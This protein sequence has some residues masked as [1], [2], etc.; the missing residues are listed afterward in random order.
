[1]SRKWHVAIVRVVVLTAGLCVLPATPAHAQQAAD[2]VERS[3]YFVE[4]AAKA[5]EWL[6]ADKPREA[7]VIFEN[8]AA[9]YADLDD[10]GYVLRAIGD[11]HVALGDFA[12]A[13]AAFEKAVS[14]RPELAEKLASRLVETQLEGEPG[15]ALI[16]ELRVAA[17]TDRRDRAL[18]QWQLA[19][20]LE[21]K[22]RALLLESAAAFR[23]L[24]EA[25]FPV[26]SPR[27]FHFAERAAALEEIAEE[28]NTLIHD[29]QKAWSALQ[30]GRL[31][32]IESA[33]KTPNA[34]AVLSKLR[35]SWVV[36]KKDG[37][38]L[39][40]ELRGDETDCK[41]TLIVEGRPVALTD[42]QTQLIRRHHERI[43]AILM[44]AVEKTSAA[45]A[46]P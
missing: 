33:D 41:T 25:E 12:A 35:A 4:Q 36:R 31:V 45:H 40:L 39:K 9:N 3:M 28:L 15:D 1:M 44:E 29:L 30:W 32:R 16:A 43:N 11:C 24:D 10:D 46:R 13:Q 19:R 2:P 18:S 21:K 5:T 6:A 14:L 7:L 20:A 42:L 38:E 37:A 26:P 17:S 8:L 34:E 27:S 23:T 22:A